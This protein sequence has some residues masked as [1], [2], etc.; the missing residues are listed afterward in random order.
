MS[1]FSD[2]NEIEDDEADDLEQ[3]IKT[4]TRT[5][6]DD[7]EDTRCMYLRILH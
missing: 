1:E 2:D 7:D 4:R 5:I 6:L 3:P